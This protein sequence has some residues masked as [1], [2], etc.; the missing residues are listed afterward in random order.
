LLNNSTNECECG[1]DKFINGQGDLCLKCV[2]YDGTCLEYCP[3]DTIE[4]SE[5]VCEGN[6]ESEA[7]A[8]VAIII[9][10]VFVV[11]V[12]VIGVFV[13]FGKGKKKNK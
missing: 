11:I 3:I 13:F 5:G 7:S 1:N 4:N 6:G 2:Y 9:F 12:V 10:V 8:T